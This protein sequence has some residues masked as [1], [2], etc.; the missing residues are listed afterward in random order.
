MEQADQAQDILGEKMAV[1]MIIDATDVNNPEMYRE[2]VRK[3]PEIVAKFGGKYLA[4]GGNVVS[5]CGEWKPERLI[6]VEFES[7]IKFQKWFNSPEYRAIK[8]LR[9]GS[10]NVNAV[11]I[12][13]C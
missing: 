4:R 6:V 2:Y 11:V 12:E 7:M 13:G 1:Y 3:V 8:H 10:S 9:E 5:V